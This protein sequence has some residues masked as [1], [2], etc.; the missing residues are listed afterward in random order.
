MKKHSLAEKLRYKFDNLMAKGMWPMIAGLALLLVVGVLVFSLIIAF[1]GLGTQG[2]APEGTPFFQLLWANLMRFIDA[3]A[4]GADPLPLALITIFATVMGIFLM[5]L[6]IGILSAGLEERLQGLRKGRSRV[7]ESGHTVILGWS[8]QVFT[9]VSELVEANRSR[10]R[11]A[12][13]IMGKADKVEMEEA[14]RDKVGDTANTRIVCRS[15]DPIDLVDLGI[16]SPDTARSIIVLAPPG[17]GGDAEAIKTVL[18]LVNRPGRRAEPYHIV[19]EIRSPANVDAARL[20]GG[21][22]VE[23][24]LVGD[25]VA[26]II[27][28]TCRQPGLS[29]VYTELLDFGGDEMYFFSDP[30]LAGK[31]Y[32]DLLLAFE[33][34]AVIGVHREDGTAAINPPMDYRLRAGD[35]LVL[36]AADE[37]SIA[38]RGPTPFKGAASAIKNGAEP[39]RGPERI[40]VLG[41]N[42]RGAAI[43]REL[44][45]YAAP[46]SLIRI[47]SSREVDESPAG[48]GLKIEHMLADS[49]SRAALEK[50]DPAFFDTI[51]LLAYSD[52]LDYQA[53]DA[54]TLVTL[55]H[56]RDMS[57]R[58]KKPFRIVSEMMDI[59]NKELA[60]VAKV[61]DF[62]VSDKLISLLLSQISENKGLAPVFQDMFDPDGAELYFKP[63]SDYVQP[64][65]DVDFATVVESARRKGQT[66]IGWRCMEKAGLEDEAYG[67]IINPAKSEPLR[68]TEFDMVIVAAED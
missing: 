22:E 60:E 66:A 39:E 6:L 16:P 62:I 10:R 54:K 7:V 5:S 45:A 12:I 3:G 53:A 30:A 1:S 50:A 47:L 57:S 67:I 9:I 24:V 40:L 2:E 48:K 46:G 15:G 65:C 59:K 63:A 14:I 58:A 44:G 55:L 41:W 64:G 43:L 4:M 11:P 34:S 35:S 56:L 33:D 52:D 28:Q 68:F 25:L 21:A 8:D 38:F 17:E 20:A 27:A 37:S 13:V 19:A 26:R 32:G 36:I 61:N 31:A 51:V 23:I 29:V 42:W 18:A 49:A